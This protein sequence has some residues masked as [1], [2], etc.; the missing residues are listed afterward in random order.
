MSLSSIQ[1]A[2]FK[3]IYRVEDVS[4][5]GRLLRNREEKMNHE[6]EDAQVSADSN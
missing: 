6:L 4:V 2:I 1:H 5:R 3:G